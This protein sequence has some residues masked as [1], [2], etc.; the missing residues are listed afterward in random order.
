[1][2]QI[3]VIG[4]LNMDLVMMLDHFPK[5]GE[6]LLSN[7]F[8][9]NPGG[10][11]ANQAYAAARLGAQVKM[12]GM[13]GTDAFGRQLLDSLQ[14]AGVSTE[15]IGCS[16]TETT[17]MAIISV[18]AQGNNQ[19]IVN[20]AANNECTMKYIEANDRLLEDSDFLLLQ[21]EIPAEA[22]FHAIKRGRQLGKTIVLNPAPAPENI[23]NEILSMID[24]LTPN[25]TEL[26]SLSGLPC[27]SL[28]QVQAAGNALLSK[29]VSSVLV[30]LGSKGAMLIQ[31]EGSHLF[32]VEKMD[33]RDTIAAGDCF[34]AAFVTALAEN[35]PMGDA[36]RFANMAASL[37]VTRP[38]AQSSIPTRAEVDDLLK[39]STAAVQI[40]NAG[41]AR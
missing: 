4:S 27:G 12:L 3:L 34:N 37:S 15:A 5:V 9:Y 6:T 26:A 1:M 36:V 16:A 20:P 14:T 18:N 32:P 33:V 7:Q 30:T 23:P 19:I 29:G 39:Q 25:E 13:V 10:K 8:Q 28:E 22:V 24:Y 17:G 21:M 40:P 31:P 35:R 11:G 38:G 41:R 2:K